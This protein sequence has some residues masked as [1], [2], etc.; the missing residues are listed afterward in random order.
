MGL[1]VWMGSGIINSSWLF[2][3]LDPAKRF[4]TAINV[5]SGGSSIAF[6]FHL[7]LQMP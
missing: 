1:S 7:R 6:Y 3:H 5:V 4:S 2:L